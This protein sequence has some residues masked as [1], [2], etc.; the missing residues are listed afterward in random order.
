MTKK[1]LG[2]TTT[3]DHLNG[4]P[5]RVEEKQFIFIFCAILQRSMKDID[6]NKQNKKYVQHPSQILLILLKGV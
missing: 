1:F 5:D 3:Q 4:Q 2:I 6:T